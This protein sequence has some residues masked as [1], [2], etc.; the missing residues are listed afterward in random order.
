VRPRQGLK[1]SANLFSSCASGSLKRLF[2]G[3]SD[4]MTNK[5]SLM[6]PAPRE[7][8]E[9]WRRPDEFYDTADK[10][11]GYLYN[12]GKK[13]SPPQ[14]LCDAYQ[15]GSFARIWQ[16][17]HGPST[18][19]L[20]GIQQEPPDAQ[21]RFGHIC[22]E[23]ETTMALDKNSRLYLDLQN[24]RDKRIPRPV[25]GE[26]RRKIAREAIPTA[27][28][29]KAEKYSRASDL[30][31]GFTLLVIENESLSDSEMARLTEPYKNCFEAIYLLS[32]QGLV[33]AWP[34]LRVLRG[35]TVL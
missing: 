14:Y 20:V 29:K 9:E 33:M 2:K 10:G 17:N 3:G 25:T 7:W 1:V 31:K 19:R 4:N 32:W 27:V 11:V 28:R 8:F 5:M 6:E 16:D 12:T 24:L 30:T 13:F 15:A 22:L 34:D 35:Q 26:E 23:I 18:V 21:L